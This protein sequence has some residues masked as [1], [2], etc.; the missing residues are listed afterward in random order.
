[1]RPRAYIG[2]TLARRLT[3][4]L[5]GGSVALGSGE[6]SLAW[7]RTKPLSMKNQGTHVKPYRKA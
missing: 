5:T 4:N 6:L 1:M 7:V 3:M 2:Y